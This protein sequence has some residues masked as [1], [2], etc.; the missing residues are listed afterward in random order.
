MD[1]VWPC[2]KLTTLWG[3]FSFRKLV[4]CF[5]GAVLEKQDVSLIK[6]NGYFYGYWEDLT[7]LQTTEWSV[8]CRKPS[9]KSCSALKL[10]EKLNWSEKQLC[11]NENCV[12]ETVVVKDCTTVFKF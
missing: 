11:V 10:N 4:S 9:R 8:F 12:A 5:F 6:G 2:P 1:G 3:W 7:F